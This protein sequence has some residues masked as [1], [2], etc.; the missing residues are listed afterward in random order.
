VLSSAEGKLK[1]SKASIA[2]RAGKAA[3]LTSAYVKVK[4]GDRGRSGSTS[5]AASSQQQRPSQST[6]TRPLLA[7]ESL[8]PVTQIGRGRLAR[9][10]LVRSKT[11]QSNYYAM[12]AYKKAD[13]M[14]AQQ[15]VAVMRERRL[16][17]AMHENP[18]VV[19]LYA[20]AQ[21]DQNLYL[22]EDY[23][24]GGDL[25]TLMKRSTPLAEDE[26]RFVSAE[27]ALALAG[28]H[29]LHVVYRNLKP[30]HVLLTKAGHVKLADF[31]A[32]KRLGDATELDSPLVT[33]TICGAPEYTA[34]E[35]LRGQGHGL[36]VDWWG[37]GVLLYELLAGYPPFIQDTVD[38]LYGA[39]LEGRYRLPGSFDASAKD[40]VKKLLV[41]D[42]AGRLG[43]LR[44]GTDEVRLH[45]WFKSIVWT[46]AEQLRLKVPKRFVSTPAGDG[47]HT[48]FPDAATDATIDHS[49]P[50]VDPYREYF[51][52]F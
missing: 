51:G 33:H 15:S 42:P 45:P 7:L 37:F 29:K 38:S 40:L 50:G 28:L 21:D 35:M 13:I 31:S 30:E 3:Q 10:F 32:A 11:Q 46:T 23:C 39:I 25:F 49:G 19:N 8:T 14:L 20:T 36:A 22:I 2:Q 4:T 52:E 16:L 6:A 5:E 44:G 17:S 26:A 27:V 43:N 47:D 12:K 9:V 34:P 24:I 41:V 48:A 18:F 1:D